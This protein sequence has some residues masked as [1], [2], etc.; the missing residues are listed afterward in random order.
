MYNKHKKRSRKTYKRGYT[1]FNT[2]M[3]ARPLPSSSKLG[4]W[5]GC[6]ND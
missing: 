3:T 5:G 6:S 4:K 1:N 2:F